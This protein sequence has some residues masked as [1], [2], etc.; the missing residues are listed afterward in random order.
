[1]D[2]YLYYLLL[3]KF[4]KKYY[5]SD[6]TIFLQNEILYVIITLVLE[7][8][9]LL[10]LLSQMINKNLDQH[11]FILQNCDQQ[12]FT[13]AIFLDLKKAFDCVDHQILLT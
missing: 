13:C 8:D 10:P 9:I 6:R 5:I 12:K 4:L 3:Q 11:N 2:Q 1:M 7:K